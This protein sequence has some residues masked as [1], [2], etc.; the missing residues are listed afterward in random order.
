MLL[1]IGQYLVIGTI[2]I[3]MALCALYALW[4]YVFGSRVPVKQSF[5]KIIGF[6]RRRRKEIFEKGILVGL[7]HY[8]FFLLYLL[9]L[10]VLIA[11]LLSGLFPR[12]EII[13]QEDNDGEYVHTEHIAMGTVLLGNERVSMVD[14]KTLCIYNDTDRSFTLMQ[15]H[16]IN[17]EGGYGSNGT[18]DQPEER[19][20]PYSYHMTKHI[21]S[22]WFKHPDSYHSKT[23]YHDQIL[24]VIE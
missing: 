16:Y 6:M 12:V 1:T 22:F 2:L 15:V 7:F 3:I 4:G 14:N 24:W 20:E 10:P 19:I 23:N 21:P 18:D 13:S 5:E 8:I 17:V 11:Y 9:A